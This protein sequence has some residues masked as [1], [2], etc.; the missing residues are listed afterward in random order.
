MLSGGDEIIIVE[1]SLTRE[2]ARPPAIVWPVIGG[3]FDLGKW[4]DVDCVRVTGNGEVGSVRRVGSAIL[5]PLIAKTSCSYTYGQIEG[6]MAARYYHG[7]VACEPGA[8][9]G[10][11]IRYSLVFDATQMEEAA[12]NAERGRLKKRFEAAVDA[13]VEALS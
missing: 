9:S 5:E 12:C 13:M 3:F 8:D 4:L 1:V 6:P 2:T 10:S 7:T 11:V